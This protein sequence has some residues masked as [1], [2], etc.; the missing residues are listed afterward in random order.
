M[1]KR[2]RLAKVSATVFKRDHV[3]ATAEEMMIWA[4]KTRETQ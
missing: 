2:G 3:V 4:R 1:S